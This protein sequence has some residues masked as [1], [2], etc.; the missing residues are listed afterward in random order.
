[1]QD[2][3][4]IKFGQNGTDQNSFNKLLRCHQNMETMAAVLHTGLKYLWD[5]VDV[6]N[7]KKNLCKCNWTSVLL[8]HKPICGLNNLFTKAFILKPCPQSHQ[9]IMAKVIHCTP[10]LN[11]W[12]NK[13]NFYSDLQIITYSK[14]QH[15][16]FEVLVSYNPLLNSFDRI[17]GTA[18]KKT[19]TVCGSCVIKRPW[20]KTI[21]YKHTACRAY[22]DI[23]HG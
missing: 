12:T 6:K 22:T 7:V 16:L 8:I 3:G 2:S 9:P 5:N 19:T 15:D 11:K 10:I 1:M 21:Y 23:S 17:S 13:W 20:L 14:G 18:R 4:G